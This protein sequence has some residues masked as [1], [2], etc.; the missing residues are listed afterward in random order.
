MKIIMLEDNGE[1]SPRIEMI[2]KRDNKQKG[3]MDVRLR[4]LILIRTRVV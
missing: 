3:I 4:C 2:E 1:E